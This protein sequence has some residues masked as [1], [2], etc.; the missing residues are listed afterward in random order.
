M[1]DRNK[2]VRVLYSFPLR[3]GADR[4]CGIA[5]QQVNGLA[6]AGADVTVFAA[7]MSRSVRPGVSVS[8]TLARGKLRVPYKV[9]GT[10]RAC[11]WHDQIVASRIEKLAG[12]IDIIHAW[13]LGALATL[14]TA[15]R[16]GI[17]TVLERCRKSATVLA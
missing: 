5:W 3:L 7:S 2:C 9:V 10:M 13:P 8:P 11:E 15:A 17:P 1:S 14:Q 12:L 4:I 16:M 6:A